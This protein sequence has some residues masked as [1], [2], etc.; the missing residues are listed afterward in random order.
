LPKKQINGIEMA[1]LPEIGWSCLL[2]D[3]RDLH[4]EDTRSPIA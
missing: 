1:D 3:E 2:V 4:Y